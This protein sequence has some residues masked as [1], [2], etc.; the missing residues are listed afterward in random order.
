MPTSRTKPPHF[1]PKKPKMRY[2]TVTC[3]F[4][5]CRH[6]KKMPLEMR[7]RELTMDKWFSGVITSRPWFQPVACQFQASFWVLVQSKEIC[8]KKSEHSIFDQP[9]LNSQQ[10]WSLSILFGCCCCC[11]YDFVA[12]LLLLL[13]LL[14]WFCGCL[15]L[16]LSNFFLAIMLGW[17]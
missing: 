3:D 9:L 7:D 11:C 16:L 4:S 5:M 15:L 1:A 17:H 12:G 14:N 6:R 8:L 2:E 13:S 10:L